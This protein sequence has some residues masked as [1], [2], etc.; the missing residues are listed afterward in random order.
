M[1]EMKENIISEVSP[2]VWCTRIS[3]SVYIYIV[4]LWYILYFKLFI[5]PQ[6]QLS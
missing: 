3:K 1:F 2:H 4:H 5:A 6:L